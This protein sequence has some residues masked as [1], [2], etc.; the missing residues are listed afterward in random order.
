MR[1]LTLQE[2]DL[3]IEEIKS[4]QMKERLEKRQN[5]FF[6]H[7][8]PVHVLKKIFFSLREKDV[9]AF[10]NAHRKCYDLVNAILKETPI[11][12]Q[13][14]SS[15]FFQ[16]LFHTND[17]V[18]YRNI[19]RMNKIFNLRRR[20]YADITAQIRKLI[21]NEFENLE[22]FP[23]LEHLEIIEPTENS[24]NKILGQTDLCI[25]LH[26]LVVLN[27]TISPV[28]KLSVVGSIIVRAPN[29]TAIKLV[30]IADVKLSNPERVTHLDI[31]VYHKIVE[32]FTNLTHFYCGNFI[33]YRRGLLR[34][35]CP[36]KQIRLV[37]AY[38]RNLVNLFAKK[39]FFKLSKIAIYVQGVKVDGPNQSIIIQDLCTFHGEMRIYLKYTKRLS[40]L[41][42]LTSLTVNFNVR[43]L[44][45]TILEK[46]FNL[47]DLKVNFKIDDKLEWTQLLRA[48]KVLKTITISIPMNQFYLNL[49]PECCPSCLHLNLIN[50][51]D[52]DFMFVTQFQ[53][54]T[55]FQI[56]KEITV[57]QVNL[58]FEYKLKYLTDIR[59]LYHLHLFDI[60]INRKINVVKITYRNCFLL[61]NRRDFILQLRSANNWS[62]F[63]QRM[64]QTNS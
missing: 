46:M 51:T 17:Q 27:I 13:N 43:T 44:T 54:L 3:H 11:V 24:I 58:I 20:D 61:I 49:I 15:P 45:R 19:L 48:S 41:D 8:L 55:F 30:N 25:S 14:Y 31:D 38:R 33:D 26:Y 2:S 40:S 37:H 6:F 64:S 21:T 42:F 4:Q 23:R 50:D 53:C 35:G 7:N 5:K 62:E 36:L 32:K 12:N 60:S 47:E 18:N 52:I 59:F 1:N 9:I 29:L 56:N 63:I 57:Q 16:N 28:S 34:K 39:K 22:I 10:I